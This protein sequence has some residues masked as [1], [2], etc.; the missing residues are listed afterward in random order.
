MRFKTL[1]IQGFK[2]FPDKT[3]LTFDSRTT[4][5]VGSN[6]NGKS[7]ISDALRWV[8]GEQGAKTLRGD[9]MEDVIFHGTQAR[10]AM[11]FAKVTLTID[12]SDG[13]LLVASEKA[14]SN[15]D[16][17]TDENK[18][19]LEPAPE[20]VI[21]RSL[22]RTGESEYLI[23]G[24]R[25]RLKDVHTLFMG[26]GLGRDGYSIIG[27]GRIDE[28][29][30]S[31][32]LGRRE[33]FEEAAGVSKF[34]FKK[35]AAERE[36]ERTQSNLERLLDIEGELKERLPR[37]EKQAEKANKAFALKERERV[38]GV[39][40]GVRELDEIAKE[41]QE[42]MNAIL[43]NQGECEHFDREISEL[44][45]EERAIVDEKCELNA[46]IDTLRRKSESAKDD[47]AET[48][49]EVAVKL[50]DIAHNTER[51]GEIREQITLSAQGGEELAEQIAELN[52]RIEGVRGEITA[53]EKEGAAKSEQLEQLSEQN[54]SLDD[55]QG[56]L[57]SE[58]AQ[59]YTCKTS[60]EI[61][62]NRAEENIRELEQQRET[63]ANLAAN[64]EG[65]KA[66]LAAN[67]DALKSSLGK[68]TEEKEETR[69]KLTGY[70]RLFESKA[71]KEAQAREELEEL[72]SEQQRCKT[73]LDVL[74]DV[75][76]AM[77]GYYGGVKA[78]MTAAKSGK[79]GKAGILGTVADVIKV[80]KQHG[81]GIEVALGSALQHVIVSDENIAKRCIAFLKEARAGRAT[82]LPLTTITGRVLE[83]VDLD[84]EDGFVGM[85]HEI[86]GYEPQYAEIIAS[87]LGR[88]AF[89]EDLDS[90]AAIA[91]KHKYKFKIVTLDGQVINAGGSFTGGSV[92][93][94]EG[95]IGRKQELE[96]LRK[97]AA[98]LAMKFEP[99]KAAHE[100]LAAE[101]AKMKLECEGFR[102]TLTRLSGEEMRL[103][104]EIN[105]A[106]DMLRRF[107][108]T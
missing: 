38:L 31:K 67:K 8:M 7:N 25:S 3:V 74:T 80:K 56:K 63:A 99:A 18:T 76:N 34:L 70:S 49:K 51:I 27:Q 108:E 61:Y 89:A 54:A 83:G 73:R 10:K 40:V 22:Y 12:N 85:G 103:N 94:S 64:Q 91:K 72:K 97:G 57:S 48:D 43:L 2:S 84:D 46:N 105:G 32:P 90:A 65:E 1:E 29:V 52:T 95:I 41:S 14:S 75:E 107:E 101:C 81:T 42:L 37:L 86:I 96:D 45:G 60:A 50:S 77:E 100:R 69:N 15:T 28:I 55:A 20:V 92:K 47:I 19:G 33:I 71:A 62:I 39:A 6:G 88:T 11:G 68:L 78:V 4:A 35:A 93:K 59:L 21:T 87:L 24:R 82:F 66:R 102:E 26:T 23:N 98:E 104:A 53:I 9:K 106:G 13:L 44:E 16:E 36:L 17:N 58:I 5:V 30:N 79:F